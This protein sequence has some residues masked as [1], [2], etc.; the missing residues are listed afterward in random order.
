MSLIII[1]GGTLSLRSSYISQLRRSSAKWLG[2]YN[3]PYI[4]AMIFYWIYWKWKQLL[5]NNKNAE[6]ILLIV[7]YSH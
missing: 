5:Y 7:A 1:Y 2:S 3:C 4:L 6:I